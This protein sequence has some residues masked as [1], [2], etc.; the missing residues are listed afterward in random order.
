M[1]E[2]I[3][4]LLNKIL[5][6]CENKPGAYVDFPFGELPICYKVKG[7][8]FAEIYPGEELKITLAGGAGDMDF[9]RITFPEAVAGGYHCPASLQPYWST[10]CAKKIPENNLFEMIEISYNRAVSKLPI[11]IQ[12]SLKKS[13]QTGI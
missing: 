10:V 2:D 7:K 8:I 9:F 11:K 1:S 5:K 3:L 12:K 13:P 4:V 6:F